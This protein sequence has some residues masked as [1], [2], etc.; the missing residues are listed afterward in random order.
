MTDIFFSYSS[1]DRDR[2][3]PVVDANLGG[4]LIKQRIARR[5]QGRPGG[6]RTIIV[7]RRED[8]AVFLHGFAKSAVDNV[9]DDALKELKIA[10][11]QFL[12][13]TDAAIRKALNDGRWIE[14]NCGQEE[15]PE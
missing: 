2:V 9:D 4:G 11:T 10:A 13:L 12:A 6:F 8:R 1:K 7:Y 5:G 15:V 14:I 3:R